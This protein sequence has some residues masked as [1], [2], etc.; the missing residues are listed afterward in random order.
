[1]NEA[2]PIEEDNTPKFTSLLTA[3][4]V[5]IGIG[6]I[7]TVLVS[8][9]VPLVV[10]IFSGSLLTAVLVRRSAHQSYGLAGALYLTVLGVL[11]TTPA[12][13]TQ[14]PGRVRLSLLIIGSLYA[15][16]LAIKA[17]VKVLL[18]WVGHKYFR[19]ETL[20]EFWDVAVSSWSVIYI[21]WNAIQF[22]DRVIRSIVLSILGPGSMAA[23]VIFVSDT[24]GRSRVFLFEISFVVFTLCVMLGFHTLATWHSAAK[25][26]KAFSSDTKSTRAA[27]QRRIESIQNRDSQQ[28]NE[29]DE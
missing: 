9:V 17:G 21:L 7:V 25:L 28:S 11:T 13:V 20:S 15:G 16:F 6:V 12:L 19:T 3:T 8:R 14:S 24:I 10:G 29:D 26:T 5:A 2:S 18:R 4:F 27:L 22:L 23:N 1:M